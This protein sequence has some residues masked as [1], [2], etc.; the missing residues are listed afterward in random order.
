MPIRIRPYEEDH[1]A[2]VRDFNR[3]L[4]GR[5]FPFPESAVPEWLPPA[6]G[7]HLYQEQ[8]LALDGGAVRGGYIL[9]LQDF[10]L[11]GAALP[12]GYYH[13]AVAEG[14]ADPKYGTVGVQLLLDALRRSPLLYALGMGGFDRPLP[15]MLQA[16]GWTLGAVPFHFRVAHPA[17]FL[18]N[19]RPLRANRARRTAMDLAA[20]SGA[21]WAGLRL[22]QL[23]RTRRPQP[24]PVAEI[25]PSFGDWADDVWHKSRLH[26]P[27]LAVRDRETLETLYPGARFLRLKIAAGG[28][29]LGW[30]VALDTAMQ[31]DQYF[32][33][34]RLGSL[35]DFLA[36]PEDA[37]PVVHAAAAFLAGRGVDL[38]VANQG[39]AAWTA[40][41]HRAGFWQGPS[42]FLFGA[43]RALAKRLPGGG[44]DPGQLFLTR[45][46]GDGPIHL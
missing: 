38:I 35:V 7:S 39:H 18:R 31:Q 27:F 36:K 11:A 28:S 41:F 44:S 40:A 34:M 13:S 15:Q 25:V 45:G 12:I 24:A 42:N 3:R 46:D 22:V 5:T 8:Y 32:G 43:S 1:V 2:A 10:S 19:I 30:A 9:K 26:Y 20:F 23:L 16:A 37:F 33:N 14:I 21:G 17:R 4:S 6:P 29:L